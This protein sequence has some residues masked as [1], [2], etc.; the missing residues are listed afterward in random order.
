ME[1]KKEW[2]LGY[3]KDKISHPEYSS[4]HSIQYDTSSRTNEDLAKY[5][6]TFAMRRKHS[7][8]RVTKAQLAVRLKAKR[9]K[10]HGL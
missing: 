9:I 6:T 2:L 4:T 8:I 5:Y 7:H 1:N 10:T 3:I